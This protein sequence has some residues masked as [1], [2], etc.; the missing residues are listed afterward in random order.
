M[1]LPHPITV[2]GVSLDTVAWNIEA[3]TRQWPAARAG[4]A[5]LP[6]VDGVAP[7]LNDD[8]DLTTLTL[9]M[10]VLGTTTAGTIP[11]GSTPMAQCRA[12][13]DQL[14]HMFGK[15]H[16]LL[17]VQEQVDAAGTL[18]Q[19]WCKVTDAIAPEVRAGGVGKFTAQLQLPEGLWQDVTPADWT[20]TPTIISGNF[21]EI[22]TL[23]GATGPI[24]DAIILVTG[25]VTNPVLTDYATGAHV[26]LNAAIPSGQFWRLNV[27]T[28]ATR[29]GA[30]LTLTSSDTTGT[31]GDGITHSGGGN[32][33][34][35]RL[36]PTVV[37]GLRRVQ[38]ALTGTGITAAT[39][40]TV[41][42]RRKYLQ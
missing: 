9:S 22:T 2:D 21:Y 35:L 10:W 16:T 28:W 15:R 42:A 3:K 17:D 32:A 36:Q 6:G 25:P 18:R 5:V 11:G 19:A 12:N 1:A 29:Y 40:I 24:N 7:S 39:A 41:R 31:S 26:Q 14:A 38:I 20:S 13:L 27:D 34:F 23:Q 33:R 8:L 30:G 4:D 37:T